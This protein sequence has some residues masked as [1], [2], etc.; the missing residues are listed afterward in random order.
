MRVFERTDWKADSAQALQ[1]FDSWVGCLSPDDYDRYV[2]PH[3]K[4]LFD[5]LK[6]LDAPVIHFG[7]DTATLIERLRDAGGDVIGVDWRIDIDEARERIGFDRAVQGNLDPIAL[8]APVD[9]MKEKVRDI[10][11]RAAGRPPARLDG[12]PYRSHVATDQGL[13]AADARPAPRRSGPLPPVQ[14]RRE[15]E[16]ISRKSARDRL[17]H[18]PEFRY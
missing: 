13:S 17:P 14:V 10:L 12:V 5:D 4:R 3:S 15:S 8:F 16:G 11:D 2:M 1:V 9:V 7:T 6:G 18:A